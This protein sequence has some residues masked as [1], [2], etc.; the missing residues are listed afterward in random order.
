NGLKLQQVRFR[1][2]TRKNYFPRRVVKHW[3]RLPR[4]V[5]ESPSLEVFKRCVDVALKDMV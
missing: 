4:E 1:L 5:V 3:N 2:D